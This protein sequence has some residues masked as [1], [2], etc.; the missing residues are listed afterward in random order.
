VII[1]LGIA[2]MVAGATTA[3]VAAARYSAIAILATVFVLAYSGEVADDGIYV[4]IAGVALV[5]LGLLS[6]TGGRRRRPAPSASAGG[7][8]SPGAPS[9][10]PSTPGA[11]PDGR[12]PRS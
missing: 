4:T 1:V 5:L 10:A 11:E 7:E 12:A 3:Y 6:I 8:A 2:T 9:E